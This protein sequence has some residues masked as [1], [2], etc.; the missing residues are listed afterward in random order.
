M[1]KFLLGLAGALFLSSSASAAPIFVLVGFTS[2]FG[3]GITAASVSGSGDTSVTFSNLT[4]DLGSC[5]IVT[6]CGGAGSTVT[7]SSATFTSGVSFTFT[8]DGTVNDLTYTTS[9]PWTV[10]QT[11]NFF[12]IATTGI[13]AVT[14][15][16]NTPGSLNF[17]FQAPASQDGRYNV[18]TNGSSVPEP[19]S[20]ALLG[21]GLV[22]L[23]LL[24]RRRTAKK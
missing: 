11:G 10:T 4:F 3:Q 22:G 5:S 20:L 19:G 6:V 9:G 24:V 12:D 17:S 18:A 21:S 16:D 1:K 15:F 8:F 14:G 2:Q 23:G 7:G 13:Y